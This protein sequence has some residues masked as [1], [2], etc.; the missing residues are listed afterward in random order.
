MAKTYRSAMG[1]PIDMDRLRLI[2]EETIAVGNMKVNARGDQL[3]P[4]GDVARSRNELMSDYYRVN[5]PLVQQ[6]EQQPPPTE[7]RVQEQQQ[8][9][10][11]KSSSTL[12]GNLAK[13]L[14]EDQDGD[15]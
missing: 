14:L 15:E 8:I 7:Q 6:A 13:Q 9:R 5:A 2:N 10:N 11:S 12:R 3:G 1:K 4:G